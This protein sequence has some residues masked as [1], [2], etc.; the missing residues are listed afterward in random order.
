LIFAL[1]CDGEVDDFVLV[2]GDRVEVEGAYGDGVEIE[3][4]YSFG[5]GAV[6]VEGTYSFGGGACSFG[7]A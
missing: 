2:F 3:G 7:R 5:G 1:G 4:T 6:E